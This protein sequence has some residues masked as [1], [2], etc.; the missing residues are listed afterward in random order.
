MT[1]YTTAEVAERL[2][3]SA[4]KIRTVAAQNGIG[5]ELGGRAGFRYTEAD[6]AAIIDALRPAEA[7]KPRR[8]KR[9]AA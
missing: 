5:I 6:V 2:R 8:R 9:R 1:T 7:V 4:R 3:C